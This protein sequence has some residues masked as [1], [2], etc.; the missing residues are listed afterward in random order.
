[1]TDRIELRGLRALGVHGVL[2]EEQ[3]RAQPFD[4]DLDVEADLSTAGHTDRLE[5]TLDYG[6][7]ADAVERVVS[8]EH[9]QLLERLAERI[10]EEVL[11]DE[12]VTSVTVTVRKLRPPVPQDLATSGVRITRKRT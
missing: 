8:A 5:D 2:P 1:M 12:R 6:A 4:V 3:T 10:A 11:G 9:H 7:M